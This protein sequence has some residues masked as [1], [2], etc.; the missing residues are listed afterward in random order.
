MHRIIYG[1]CEVAIKMW[2][3]NPR[4]RLSRNEINFS[5]GAYRYGHNINQTKR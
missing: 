3:V 1:Q 4:E 5:F 2:A